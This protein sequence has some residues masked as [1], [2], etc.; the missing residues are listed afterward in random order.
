MTIITEEKIKKPF[1]SIKSYHPKVLLNLIQYVHPQ[2]IALILTHLEPDKAWIILE[3]LPF[4]LLGDVSGRIATLDRVS[5]EIIREI[6][7]ALEKKLAQ[8]GEDSLD[9]IAV[10]GVE[11]IVKILNHA[12]SDSREQ[13]LREIAGDD[14]E[15]AEVIE[16]LSMEKKPFRKFWEKLKG[17]K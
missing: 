8:S 7:Q 15:L 2:I 17:N 3:N 6:E 4:E 13:I 11:N 16:R 10:D 1:D 12:D 9:Y 5:P 14:P